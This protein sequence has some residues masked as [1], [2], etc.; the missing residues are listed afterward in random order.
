M[1]TRGSKKKIPLILGRFQ[2]R[3]LRGLWAPRLEISISFR[4]LLSSLFVPICESKFGRL[5]VLKPGIFV[6][7][8][9][10]E[11]GLTIDGISGGNRIQSTAGVA[12]KSHTVLGL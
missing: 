2:D 4:F 7:S 1:D 12:A 11:T 3:I 8:A 6:I 9:A 10:L 5:G